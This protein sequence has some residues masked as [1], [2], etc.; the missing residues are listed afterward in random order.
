[1]RIGVGGELIGE[2]C[3]QLVEVSSR[4]RGDRLHKEFPAV[5]ECESVPEPNVRRISEDG[6]DVRGGKGGSVLCAGYDVG[7]CDGVELVKVIHS[8]AGAADG[9][10]VGGD[11]EV[12]FRGIKAVLDVVRVFVHESKDSITGVIVRVYIYIR[13]GKRPARPLGGDLF[14]HG[15]YAQAHQNARRDHRGGDHHDERLHG[16]AQDAVR[17]VSDE[18]VHSLLLRL[19]GF[20]YL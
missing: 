7:G 19:I 6:G 14:E 16:V 10:G 8:H 9:L 4:R 5:V 3:D 15:R 13:T 17:G 1:M 12:S 2:T 20:V 18:Y 11:D